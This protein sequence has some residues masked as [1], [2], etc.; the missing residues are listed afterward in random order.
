MRQTATYSGKV[1]PGNC[2]LLVPTSNWSCI[3][4]SSNKWNL[5][6]THLALSLENVWFTQYNFCDALE[7]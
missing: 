6:G 1:G 3:S 4:R 5:K 7:C 2:I